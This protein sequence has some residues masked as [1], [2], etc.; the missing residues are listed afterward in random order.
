MDM[1]FSKEDEAF[2]TEVRNFLEAKLP[3][4]VAH[5]VHNG[6]HVTRPEI[7]AWHKALYEQGWITPNWPEAWGGRLDDDPEVY[8]R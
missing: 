3:K 7:M 4:D 8:F 5:K 6:F 1:S 2:R